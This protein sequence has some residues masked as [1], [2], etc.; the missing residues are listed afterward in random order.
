[1][2]AEGQLRRIINA[3]GKEIPVPASGLV[4]SEMLAERL[5]VE[6][7]DEVIVEMLEGRRRISAQPV[8]GII[9][10]FLGLSVFMNK[11]ALW[12]IS[13]EPNVVNGAFLTVDELARPDL[14]VELKKFPAVTGVASPTTMLRSFEEQLAE[15]IL[16][17]SSFL[18]GF[19]GVIAVGVIYNAARISLSERGRELASLRVMGFHRKEVTALLLGEQAIITLLAIPLGWLIGYSLSYAITAGLQTDIYRIPFIAE[20]RTY[21]WSAVFIVSAA[22]AS[23]WVIRRRLDRMKIVEVLKTRE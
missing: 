4:L 11:E 15:G 5:A 23:G 21:L 22:I 12:R 19:A 2:E 9:E 17:A 14:N 20:P 13:G 10:D 8:N 18:L 6:I 16:I 1:L 3:E 7:G